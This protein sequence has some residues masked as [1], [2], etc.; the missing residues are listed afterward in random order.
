MYNNPLYG[1]SHYTTPAAQARLSGAAPNGATLPTGPAPSG[2][3]FDQ[4]Y[5]TML[6]HHA[7]LARQAQALGA[8]DTDGTV[9][10]GT[11]VSQEGPLAFRNSPVLFLHHFCTILAAFEGGQWRVPTDAHMTTL[12][13]KPQADQYT[14]QRRD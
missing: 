9:Y 4:S 13:L 6:K 14:A 11:V 2:I 1:S 3:R 5:A 12:P 7:A 8:K 10:K